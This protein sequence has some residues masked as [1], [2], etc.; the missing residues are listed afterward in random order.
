LNLRIEEANLF[1]ERSSHKQ[2]RLQK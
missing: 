2:A 1:D